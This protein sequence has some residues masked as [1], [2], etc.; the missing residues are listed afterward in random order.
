VNNVACA[1]G[2]Y[3]NRTVYPLTE[4]QKVLNMTIGMNAPKTFQFGDVSNSECGY[5]FGVPYLHDPNNSTAAALW[6]QFSV[7]INNQ[8]EFKVFDG[9]IDRKVNYETKQ[10]TFEFN[11]AL[12]ANHD[13]VNGT[14]IVAVDVEF[15]N[16]G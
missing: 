14:A 9:S 1:P 4:P 7:K 3:V 6:S 5:A 16:S 10:V 8:P 12:N 11:K 13:S 15:F 2:P